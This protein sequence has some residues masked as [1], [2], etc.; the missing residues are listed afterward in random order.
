MIHYFLPNLSPAD[1]HLQGATPVLK[2]DIML[3]IAV[4]KYIV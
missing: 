4:I 2:P 3:Y 1:G